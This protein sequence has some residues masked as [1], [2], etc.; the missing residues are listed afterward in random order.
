M[1]IYNV[2]KSLWLPCVAISLY[3]VAVLFRPLL[4][5]DE[6]RYM[7]VA[8]EMFLHQ[9]W[10]KPLTVNFEP[11]HHK[12]PLLFWLINASWSVFG[13]SRWAG[14]IPAVL[15]STFCIYL[16]AFLGK[17]IFPQIHDRQR[18]W[19]ILAGS[20]PFM[21]YGTLVMFDFMLCAW[22]LLSLICLYH[23]RQERRFISVFLL[24]IC[25]GLGV[26]TKGPVAYL[27]VLP[28]ALLGPLWIKDF[29][30]SGQWYGGILIAVMISVLP[31]L[32]WLVPV[33][34]ASDQNFAFWLLWNQTVGRVTGN[35]SE[36]HDR[37]IWFYLPFLPAIFMPWI[38][39]PTFWRKISVLGNEINAHEGLKFLM[40]WI[41]PVFVAF[42]LIVG[43]QPHYLVPLTPGMA[44]LVF[45]CLQGVETK[46]LAKV[47]A[48]MFILFV[49]AQGVAAQTVFNKYTLEPMS[50]ILKAQP[51]RPLAFV[52]NYHGE[53]GFM[54]RR[55]APVDDLQMNEIDQW[56]DAHPD[57]WAAIR[58]TD[59]QPE[60]QKYKMIFSYPYRG[61]NLGIFEK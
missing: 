60:I 41:V 50:E 46:V 20:V 52:R 36:A 17:R 19:L 31:V 18:I 12:P 39:I 32:L 56:F 4:P 59:N 33:L 54:A 22:V 3:L 14:L 13:V 8:W 61:K 55:E 26:L 23:F 35:F 7:T 1:N 21:V 49:G 58:Y 24:G 6:T 28:V 29:S 47:F 51:A 48:A 25:L 30:R 15:A 10:L 57:G 44:L 37:P 43:K 16:T 11:Y 34:Q 38:F 2:A 9:G 53:V 42:S 27:Y 5:I 40:C 45:Y